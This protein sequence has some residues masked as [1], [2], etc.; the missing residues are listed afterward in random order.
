M[1]EL[2]D[3]IEIYVRDSNI[4]KE[5]TDEIA[6]DLESNIKEEAPYREGR[7]RRSIR[8]DSRVYDDYS[9]IVGYYDEGLA[10]HGDY[11]L[12]GTKPHDIFIAPKNKKALH[13]GGKGGPFS[14]GHTIPHPGTKPND[15]LGRG[16][17]KTVEAYR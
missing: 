15:F 2:S 13:W 6:M 11:V 3:F 1:S 12:M 10:P 14:K 4:L 5:K 8:T 9:I 17:S 16:L 7:L